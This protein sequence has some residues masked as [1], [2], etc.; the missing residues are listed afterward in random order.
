MLTPFRIRKFSRMFDALDINGDGG[1]SA[2]DIELAVASWTAPATN[3]P[4]AP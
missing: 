4:G 3:F 1:L 2:Q